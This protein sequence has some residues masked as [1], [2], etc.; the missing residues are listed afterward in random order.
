MITKPWKANRPRWLEYEC[1]EPTLALVRT[2]SPG[3]KIWEHD[4]LWK[5]VKW[6]PY[7]YIVI[8][9]ESINSFIAYPLGWH[10]ISKEH[11]TDELEIYE[12]IFDFY[13]KYEAFRKWLPIQWPYKTFVKNLEF[14]LN[15]AGFSL[16]R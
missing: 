9:N 5:I 1:E 3:E 14:Y 7:F 15:N 12:N 4:V 13:M 10:S 11:A 6:I 16:Y 8:Y 2:G